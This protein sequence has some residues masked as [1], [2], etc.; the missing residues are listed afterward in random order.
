V[1]EALFIHT[2]IVFFSLAF[3]VVVEAGMMPSMVAMVAMVAWSH[4]ADEDDGL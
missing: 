4:E 2:A 1:F 3:V